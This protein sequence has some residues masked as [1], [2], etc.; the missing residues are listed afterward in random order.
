MMGFQLG[1]RS[2]TLPSPPFPPFPSP[3][4]SAQAAPKAPPDSQQ[5]AK[6]H[7]PGCGFGRGA[8]VKLLR[9]QDGQLL[10]VSFS[11]F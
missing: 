11:Y 1:R 3:A 7:S 9:L 5:H 6:L 4:R 8:N 2:L 10:F